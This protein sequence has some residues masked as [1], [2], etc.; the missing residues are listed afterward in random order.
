[1]NEG[2]TDRELLQEF[3]EG[4]SDM[5]FQSLVE[6]HINLVFATAMR[7]LRDAGGA[8]EI[9]QNVF[10]ALARK[11]AWLRG[12]VA[13]A[14]WLHKTTVLESRQW[15]RGELRRKN[16]E[17]TAA[18]LGT[19]M[20]TDDA[21]LRSLAAVLDEGLMELRE[22]D[23][24]AVMLRYLE[25]RSHREVGSELGIGEDAARKR[26]DK[27]LEQL[28][29][30]FQRRGYA[31]SAVTATAE[32]LRGASAHAAPAGTAA[33]ITKAAV[34]AGG[35]ASFGTL[36]IYFGKFMGLT[37]A[38]TAMICLV[39]AATPVA[40]EWRA[41]ASARSEE[42][43]LHKQLT[44]IG[45][46]IT[47][48]QGALEQLQSRLRST[49]FALGQVRAMAVA[50]LAEPEAHL[51]LW[52]EK[53]DY[54]RVPKQ[55]L[56]NLTLSARA[57]ERGRQTE[58]PISIRNGALSKALAE[59]LGVTPEEEARVRNELQGFYR[60]YQQLE[61]AFTYIT[62]Q[63]LTGMSF[64][65]HDDSYMLVTSRFPEQ[66]DILRQQLRAS[67]EQT[68]GKDRAE[69][70]WQQAENEFREQ[71]NEFGALERREAVLLLLKDGRI[72]YCRAGHRPEEKYPVYSWANTMPLDRTTVPEV[73]RPVL[74]E[75][76]TRWN[77]QNLRYE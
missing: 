36:G 62:N 34:S 10:V 29:H 42:K 8:Q 17:E 1:M 64:S 33:A 77:L 22:S 5:A 50:S 24:Q 43:S 26:I 72:A 16:R 59:A 19:T 76:K 46:Q 71:L 40:Y 2:R 30:F 27:A 14:G 39:V 45:D 54:V 13:L 68:L 25:G 66:G 44:Q 18:A 6:R 35:A 69:I 32:A 12:E 75:W 37:K 51:Y 58:P 20:K 63:P 4:G 65:A 47:I 56:T 48:Q 3:V 21:L 70:V 41:A 38:Q 9:T 49:D 61:Q 57:P 55:M 52:D 11:A 60:D 67:L 53:S 28:T 74:E 15:W 23:R 7:R 31:V 73:F